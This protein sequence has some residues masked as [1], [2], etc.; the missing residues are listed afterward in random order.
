MVFSS[1][2]FLYVFLPLFLLVY[3]LTPSKFRNIPA[4]IGSYI[5]YAWGAPTFVFVLLI[6]SFFDYIIGLGFG[7]TQIKYKRKLLLILALVLNLGLLIVFKY[8]GFLTTQFNYILNVF[9][10]I[11]LPVPTIVLPLGISFFTFQKLSY[12]IDVYR[13]N[14]KPSK[15]FINYALYVSLFP[16]LIAGPIVRYHD[17]DLQLRTR[18]HSAEHFCHGLFR[19]IIGLSKKV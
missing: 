12:I 10:L 14:V 5:F 1:L 11:R 15:S 2:I 16:Q 18:V 4:L 13:E 9:H 3:Y 8:A 6:S 19:F 17:V 7:K